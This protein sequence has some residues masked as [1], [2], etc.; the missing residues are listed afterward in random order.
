MNQDLFG[1][2]P[3]SGRDGPVFEVESNLLLHCTRADGT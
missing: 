3:G 2:I 1:R